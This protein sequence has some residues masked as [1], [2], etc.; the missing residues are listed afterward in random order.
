[1]CSCV[2]TSLVGCCHPN[3]LLDCSRPLG[4]ALSFSHFFTRGLNP[5]NAAELASDNVHDE[6]VLQ[7]KFLR[8]RKA[9]GLDNKETLEVSGDHRLYL[10]FRAVFYVVTW[11]I[12]N[13]ILR[14]HNTESCH[15]TIPL[16]RPSSRCSTTRSS[17]TIW[18]C[19]AI[20]WGTSCLFVANE[21]TNTCSKPSKQTSR[22]SSQTDSRPLVP[23]KIKSTVRN[24][25][26]LRSKMIK[27]FL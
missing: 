23:K 12:G 3:P 14:A 20:I 16:F 26:E 22:S 10:R 6:K 17:C 13:S 24:W 11:I 1:M 5:D 8:L 25:K 27:T 19:W 15:Q 7:E 18:T 2:Q 9:K 4:S 21:P